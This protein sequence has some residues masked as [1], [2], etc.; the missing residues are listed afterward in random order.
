[1]LVEIRMPLPCTVDE[2]QVGQLHMVMEQSKANSGG[3]EGVEVL[4]N[5]SYD[6]S[7]GSHGVSE[8][9]STRVPRNKGQFTL[10][11][12]LIASKVPGWLSSL[13]AAE[14]MVLWEESWNAYPDCRTV[15]TSAYV[16][17]ETFKID[18]RSFHAAGPP[19]LENALG[20][21]EEELKQREVITLDI[22]D[23]EA[24]GVKAP[25]HNDPCNRTSSR[26]LRVPIMR[27]DGVQSSSASIH[28]GERQDREE[29]DKDDVVSDGGVLYRGGDTTH[30]TRFPRQK[31]ITTALGPWW[32]K[33]PGPVMTC[34]KLFRI[35]FKVLLLQ[36]PLE[37][38]VVTMNRKL[39]TTAHRALVGS[40]DS[41]FGLRMLRLR[42]LEEAARKELEELT[43][44]AELA[45][46]IEVD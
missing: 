14:A 27:C 4:K 32:T 18:C 28:T 20:L 44:S 23:P 33:Y 7:D 31:E 8:R 12:L 40:M 26:A 19:T 38:F 36:S 45:C 25:V 3:G 6:N 2:Y 9:S 21:S 43:Q 11:K 39:L 46:S 15:L 13:F 16:S 30:D 22:T 1:M 5:E 35:D 34:Y 17:N 10:K 29:T 37:S 24:N 41:W 42:Q